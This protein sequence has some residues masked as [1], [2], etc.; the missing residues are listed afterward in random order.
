MELGWMHVFFI[1]NERVRPTTCNTS[2]LTIHGNITTN[3]AISF[4][5]ALILVSLAFQVKHCQTLAHS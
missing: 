5:W 2:W 1:L 4:Y 3:F